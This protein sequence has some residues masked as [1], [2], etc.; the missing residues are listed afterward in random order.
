[1]ADR[2][3]WL[4]P[5]EELLVLDMM[6]VP[7]RHIVKL[8]ALTL[9]RLS[10]IGR[11]R[12]EQV[13][14]ADGLLLLPQT[15]TDPRLVILSVAAQE[16]LREAPNGDGRPYSREHISRVFRQ[17]ARQA[18]LRDFHFHDLRHHGA[19]KAL[20]CGYSDTV[21]MALGGWKNPAMM[22][23]YAAATNRTLRAA[24]EA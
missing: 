13:R 23:R 24:A 5:E 15:K 4:A 12:R 21:V 17:H 2:V 16:I 8:A 22:R 20:N 1:V 14:L 18:G 7:F 11:L 6:P 19:T 3:R 9:M 10:E